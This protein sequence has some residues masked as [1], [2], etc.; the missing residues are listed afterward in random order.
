VY[1]A[2]LGVLVSDATAQKLFPLV[3]VALLVPIVLLVWRKT[4][5]FAQF[6]LLG[7]VSTAVVIA[8]TAALVLWVMVTID[9]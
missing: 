2:L 6:M 3:L 8:V 4:R 9:G 5:R 1:A 7:I